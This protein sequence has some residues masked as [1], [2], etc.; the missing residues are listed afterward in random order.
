MT[1]LRLKKV[2]IFGHLCPKMDT[3]LFDYLNLRKNRLFPSCQI[4][5]LV[6]ANISILNAEP[7]AGLQI[8]QDGEW[9]HSSAK[10][11]LRNKDLI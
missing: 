2:S 7:A 8:L 3:F 9:D 6:A 11:T 1:I 4:C 5:N 10:G